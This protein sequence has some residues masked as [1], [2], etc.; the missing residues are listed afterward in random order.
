V[1]ARSVFRE[2][3]TMMILCKAN[4]Q[5]TIP[6]VATGYEFANIGNFRFHGH[7]LRSRPA[8]QHVVLELIDLN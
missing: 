3:A 1:R 7:E 6:I 4:L 2:A 5:I 8:L